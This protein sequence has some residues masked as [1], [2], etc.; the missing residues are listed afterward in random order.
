[1]FLVG[2][3]VVLVGCKSSESQSA[4]PDPN[5]PQ[6]VEIT[7]EITAVSEV[8]AVDRATRIV[9]LQREDGTMFDLQ[10]GQVARNFDQITVGDQVRVRYKA[11]LSATRRPAGEKAESARG[12]AE[13]ARTTAGAKPGAGVGMAATVRVKVESI[14]LKTNIVVLSLASGELVSHRVATPE[15]TSF[16]K[17]LKVGDVVQI[18]YAEA[19]ALSVEAL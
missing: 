6:S 9:T 8:R 2:A 7:D 11:S 13:A 18:D 16:I 15:G 5:A 14:D 3:L 12:A 4:A 10:V 17:G 19:L 1:M